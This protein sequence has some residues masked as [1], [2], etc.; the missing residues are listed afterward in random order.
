MEPRL[1][2]VYQIVRY[3][4]MMKTAGLEVGQDPAFRKHLLVTKKGPILVC[5][6]WNAY[7]IMVQGRR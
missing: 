2:A 7:D 6:A 3:G 4:E 5:I 1:S